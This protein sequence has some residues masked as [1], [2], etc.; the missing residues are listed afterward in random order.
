MF[1]SQKKK[2]RGSVSECFL[3][4]RALFRVLKVFFICIVDVI[5]FNEYPVTYVE[6]SIIKVNLNYGIFGTLLTNI[7]RRLEMFYM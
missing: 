3:Y 6:C 4:F 7:V 5:F 1:S 2:S